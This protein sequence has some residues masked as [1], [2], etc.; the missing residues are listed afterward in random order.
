LAAANVLRRR[1]LL[2]ERRVRVIK[3]RIEGQDFN[4]VLMSRGEIAA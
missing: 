3:P 1:L 4:D 2:M